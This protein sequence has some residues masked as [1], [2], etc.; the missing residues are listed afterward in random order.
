MMILNAKQ[1]QAIA[2]LKKLRV[3]ALFMEPGTG[4]TLTAIKIIESSDT[5]FCLFIVP[6]QSKGNFEREL[7]KWSFRIDY[8]IVGVESLSNSD[9]LYLDLLLKITKYQHPFVVVDESLKIKNKDAKRTQRV[10]EIGKQAYYRLIMNGTPVS[11]NI[12]DLWTQMQFLSPKILGMSENQFKDTF[13]E[14]VKIN[15]HGKTQEIIKKYWNMKYL[16]SL[17]DPYVFDAKLKINVSM[18]EINVDYEIADTTKYYQLKEQMLHSIGF[19][20]D[21]QFLAYTQQMQQSYSTDSNKL[22]AV[23]ALVNKL[24]EPT[25]LFCKFVNTQAVLERKFPNCK[26]LT[27]GKGALGLN[28]Q[29]YKNMIFVDK[30]WDYAQ[31][32]QAKRRIYRIGQDSNVKYYELTGNVGLEKLMNRS[33]SNKS[34][35]LNLFKEASNKKE[36]INEF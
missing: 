12:V 29:K 4:K 19:M 14:Y 16:Y 21:I 8:Q 2:K 26:V 35:M 31:L 9:K 27:Y 36:F 24:E 20:N 22:K 25:I 10:I 32:E 6:F 23:S 5:D 28:L 1:R 30:T 34:T 18:Q 3:G 7:K 33:I 11:K 15:S 13:I 17:I